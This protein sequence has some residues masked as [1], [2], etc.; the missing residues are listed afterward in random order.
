M[1][2][3]T[4]LFL[5]LFSSQLLLSQETTICYDK[6]W[7]VIED[8]KDASFYRFAEIDANNYHYII[9]DYFISGELQ[10]A[11]Q[12][13][14]SKEK[15]KIGEWIWYYQNGQK[16]KQG[17]YSEKGSKINIWNAWFENS[18]Q[19]YIYDYTTDYLKVIDKWNEDGSIQ[20]KNGE[21]II[22]EKW[23]NGTIKDKG[24][25]KNKLKEGKWLTNFED[26]EL[27][28]IE[29]YSKGKFINGISYRKGKEYPYTI[30]HHMPHYKTCEN[31]ANLELEKECTIMAIQRYAGKVIYEQ[32]AI[33]NDIEGKVYVNF[34]VSPKGKITNVY[35]LRGVHY[36]LDNASL[37][38]IKKMP[39]F[40]PGVQ[41]GI[42]VKT[43]YKIPIVFKLS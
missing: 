10:C 39:P 17:T 2:L 33:D 18:Q 40:I 5:F 13:L 19:N 38:H 22:I 30:Q 6:D 35:I 27:K 14:T 12:Y 21:G 15:K 16:S 4:A 36:L 24:Q 20:V 29:N 26:G 25:I 34:D 31:N 43:N 32:E 9:K 41:D 11:G 8:S 28:K 3:F 37:K 7:E 42:K 23:D 1:K